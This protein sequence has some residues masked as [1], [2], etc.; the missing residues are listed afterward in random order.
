MFKELGQFANLMRQLPRLKEEMEKLQT[1]LGQITA[2]GDAGAGMVRVRVNGRMEVVSC[3]LS[4][5]VLK[6]GDKEM[7]EDLIKAAVN[8][9]LTRVRQQAAEETSRMASGMGLPPGLN[10]PGLT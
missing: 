2:D 7:L 4:P 1:R 6:P 10:L 9:A 5:D 8:Q 3:E